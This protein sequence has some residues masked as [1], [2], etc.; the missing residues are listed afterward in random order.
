MG[1]GHIIGCGGRVLG[2]HKMY[3]GMCKGGTKD[4]EE[5]VLGL[6]RNKLGKQKD[7]GTKGVYN[8][9]T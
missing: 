5:R 4:R 8:V 6:G 3:C 7:K 1:V 2:L 9:S